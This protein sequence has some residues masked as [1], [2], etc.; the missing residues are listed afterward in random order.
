MFWPLYVHGATSPYAAALAAVGL[1]PDNPEGMYGAL[2]AFIKDPVRF[3]NADPCWPGKRD[4]T[5]AYEQGGVLVFEWPFGGGSWLDQAPHNDAQVRAVFKIPAGQ[6]TLPFLK[7]LYRSSSRLTGYRIDAGKGWSCPGGG[8]FDLGNVVNQAVHAAQSGIASVAH[9]ASVLRIPGANLVG[10][11]LTGKDPIEGLK[12][13]VNNFAQ[14]ANLAKHVASGD[15]SG[16]AA[17]IT[18]QAAKLGVNLPPQAVQAAVTAV[19]SGKSPQEVATAAMG[20]AYHDAWN[21]ATHYGQI[22]SA[23]LPPPPGVDY[24]PNAAPQGTVVHP[25]TA[26]AR[27]TIPLPSARVPLSP[28]AHAVAV[29]A[30]AHAVQDPLRGAFGAPEGATAW[31]CPP[32]QDCDWA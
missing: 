19:A 31:T 11:L 14:A 32:G 5:I 8:G 29:P 17:D 26:L 10:N 15:L 30:F 6:Q 7:K 28:V 12:A 18:S 2:M 13:D 25:L 16:A 20:D 4:A 1:H 9:V 22:A 3:K 21:V 27:K 23:A 24:H